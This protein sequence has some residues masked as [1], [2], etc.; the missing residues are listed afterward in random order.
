MDILAAEGGVELLTITIT[1]PAG[2]PVASGCRLSRVCR[3]SADE[4]LLLPAWAGRH[5]GALAFTCGVDHAHLVDGLERVWTETAAADARRAGCGGGPAWGGGGGGVPTT[6]LDL[7]GPTMPRDGAANAFLATLLPKLPVI[8]ALFWPLAVDAAA[9]AAAAIGAVACAAVGGGD[10]GGGGLSTAGP[11]TV[12]RRRCLYASATTMAGAASHGSGL[13]NGSRAAPMSLHPGVLL[14]EVVRHAPPSGL[15]KAIVAR[16]LPHRLD[17][18]LLGGSGGG[19]GGDGGGRAVAPPVPDREWPRALYGGDIRRAGDGA[20]TCYRSVVTAPRRLPPPDALFGALTLFAFNRLSRT[21]PPPPPPP[22]V[23]PVTLLQPHEAVAGDGVGG[24]SGTPGRRAGGRAPPVARAAAA[25]AAA[26][27]SAFR[28]P[29][30]T[31]RRSS[32]PCDGHRVGNDGLP[33]AIDGGR[34]GS[35]ATAAASRAARRVRGEGTLAA[36]TAGSGRRVGDAS[37]P[38]TDAESGSPHPHMPPPSPLPPPPPLTRGGAGVAPQPAATAA[39][40]RRALR[41][42]AVRL[43]AGPYTGARGA[44]PAAAPPP[45]LPSQPSPSTSTDGATATAAAVGVITVDRPRMAAAADEDDIAALA[46][47]GLNRRAAERA[48][49]GGEEARRRR[50]RRGRRRRPRGRRRR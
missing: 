2:R 11:P 19:S 46:D 17:A 32:P 39:S 12:V 8:D 14:P 20:T 48:T 23:V 44:Q 34:G 47:R 26:P 43:G 22:C 9:A 42:H 33:A 24:G 1:T 16:L 21:P 29:S 5:S 38:L 27:P 40:V 31:P 6:G 3:S 28:P 30:Q 49:A 45:S 37:L 4:A 25:A 50:G 7:L 10:P 15:V 18:P 41:M 36:T 13:C 35:G